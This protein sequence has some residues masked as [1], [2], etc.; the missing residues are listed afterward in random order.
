M[1]IIL[2][3][4]GAVLLFGFVLYLLQATALPADPWMRM[5]PRERGEVLCA[6]NGG[7]HSVVVKLGR[8]YCNDGARY[9]LRYPP[10]EQ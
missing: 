2:A 6:N 9:K 8:A 3:G 1:K 4:T 5:L 7:L 10:N